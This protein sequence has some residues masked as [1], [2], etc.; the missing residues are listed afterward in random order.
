MTTT[1]ERIIDKIR[2]LQAHAGSGRTVEE[3]AAFAA[4]VRRL[5]LEY[6]IS[7][8]E[9]SASERVHE[10]SVMGY[11]VYDLHEYKEGTD[12]LLLLLGAIASAH[13]C[14]VALVGLRTN[15]YVIGSSIDRWTVRYMFD[16]LRRNC[17]RC[18]E[19]E[20]RRL[21]KEGIERQR[22]VWL[23]SFRTGFLATITRRYA[24]ERAQDAHSGSQ[25]EEGAVTALVVTSRALAR[26]EAHKAS[27]LGQ[28]DR[29]HE[30]ELHATD[31]DGY[32]A[33]VRAGERQNLR[34]NGLASGV[35]EAAAHFLPRETKKIGGGR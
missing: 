14:T 16:V 8:E 4:A 21:R 35:A 25:A 29:E 17:E 24:E 28:P 12:Y 15:V 23:E 27:I 34:S 11:D 7:E 30:A 19:A 26:A 31:A 2:K 6:H 33:G 10:A 32:H 9:L 3:Q 22:Y 13:L 20:K 1:Q 5:M 18:A